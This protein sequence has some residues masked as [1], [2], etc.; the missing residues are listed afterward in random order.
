M[1]AGETMAR[2]NTPRGNWNPISYGFGTARCC[3][4]A[5]LTSNRQ[6]ERER[7]G[8]YRFR[9]GL[10]Q[11]EPLYMFPPS[12][13]GDFPPLKYIEYLSR[14]ARYLTGPSQPSFA[15]SAC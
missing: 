7:S 2:L 9:T 1:A 5:R 14:G 10:V 13:L 4:G 6:I 12:S 8:W 3:C 11:E 15:N